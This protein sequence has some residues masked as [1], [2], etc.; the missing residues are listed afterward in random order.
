[1]EDLKRRQIQTRF[2]MPTTPADL[3][4]IPEVITGRTR[5]GPVIPAVILG[6]LPCGHCGGSGRK[7]VTPHPTGTPEKVVSDWTNHAHL[8]ES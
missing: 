6:F 7:P 3:P 4:E 5:P 8:I 2:E 1:M